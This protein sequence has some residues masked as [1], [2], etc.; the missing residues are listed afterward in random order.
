MTIMEVPSPKGYT[1][2]A[3]GDVI[4]ARKLKMTY[5]HFTCPYCDCDFDVDRDHFEYHNGWHNEEW[6]TTICPCCKNKISSDA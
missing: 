3:W 4:K 6:Y 2:H 1:I 5:R